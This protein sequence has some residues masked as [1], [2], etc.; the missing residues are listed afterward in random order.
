MK[1]QTILQA[2][3]KLVENRDEQSLFEI[4]ETL[5]TQ[6]FSQHGMA[7][8]FSM[9]LAPL[10]HGCESH[11]Y[12]WNAFHKFLATRGYMEMNVRA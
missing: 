3:L 4:F 8:L 6:D 12:G 7:Q 10:D 5:E 2:G 1:K 9:A 11:T